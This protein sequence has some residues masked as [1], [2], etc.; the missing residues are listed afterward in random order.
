MNILHKLTFKKI[1]ILIGDNFAK[2]IH[3][4]RKLI[5][6]DI[7]ITNIGDKDQMKSLVAFLNKYP[8]S[9]IYLVL[10]LSEQS[11]E[12]ISIPTSNPFLFKK[13]INR[14][15]APEKGK[16]NAIKG[17]YKITNNS[18]SKNTECVLVKIP[19]VSPLEDWLSILDNVSNV[20]RAIYSFPVEM[21]DLESDISSF[22]SL[23]QSATAN[24]KNKE[25]KKISKVKSK[26]DTQTKDKKE[27]KWVFYVFQSETSGIRFAITKNDDLIFTRLLHYRFDNDHFTKDK[28]KVIK[29][30]IIGTIKYLK[31]LDF[32]EQEGISVYL[33]VDQEFYRYFQEFQLP[34]FNFVYVDLNLFGKSLFQDQEGVTYDKEPDKLFMHYFVDKGKFNGFIS[35]NLKQEAT[36]YENNMIATLAVIVIFSITAILSAIPLYRISAEKMSIKEN[37]KD[38]NKYALQ[39]ETIREEKFGFDIDEDKVIDVASL[40]GKLMKRA[41]D[42][43]TLL[44]EFYKYVPKN[45]VISEID[46]EEH[47][48]TQMK[49]VVAAYFRSEGLSFEEIFS[50]YDAFLRSI[51]KGFPKYEIDHSDL[52]DTI[53]FEKTIESLPINIQIIGPVR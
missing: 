44:F 25:I 20:V 12:S 9:P 40:H 37:I 34:N 24:V 45:I 8:K 41:Q 23:D 3:Y 48:E 26:S 36:L 49:L 19:V 5:I 47:K 43:I 33:F 6:E 21:Q 7:I 28:V 29:N 18:K 50:A 22:V 46:W 1:V 27:S 14:R 42:P 17:F 4:S 31:R 2:V 39:L 32:N 35:P 11:F 38:K 16:E 10:N 15:I 52:P 51:R 30:E 53:S 13:L